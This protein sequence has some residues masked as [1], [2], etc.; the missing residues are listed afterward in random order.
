M[1][2][3]CVP[4]GLLHRGAEPVT[5]PARELWLMLQQLMLS[6]PEAPGSSLGKWSRLA[7][8]ALTAA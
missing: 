5:A 8:V 7:G 2:V 6:A 1:S 4:F 3:C